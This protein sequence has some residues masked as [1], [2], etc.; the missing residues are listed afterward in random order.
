[1][2]I[3][4]IGDNVVDRYES[5][6]IMFPGGNAL[7]VAVFAR[8]AG[9]DAAYIGAIGADAAGALILRSLQ[10]EGVD[11]SRLR[12]VNGPNAYADVA[13]VDGDRQFIKSSVGVSRF[14]PDELDQRLLDDC[15]L[16]HTSAYSGLEKWVREVRERLP[17]SFDFSDQTDPDYVRELAPGLTCALFSGSG[18]TAEA[19]EDLARWVT[20]L[21]T[22][23]ALV[24][25]GEHGVVV[26]ADNGE[27]WTQAARPTEVVD[28]LGAGD[29]FLAAFLVAYLEGVPLREATARSAAAAAAACAYHG[30]FGRGGP[31]SVTSLT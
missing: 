3:V 9:A 29:A 11:I 10:E 19:C 2:R 31:I 18:L 15:D 25:R 16:A 21:G 26:C 6:G 7:N 1:M 12:V 23:I 24:S 20:S 17:I 13:I 27:L 8:R 4:G 14:L 30:A 22:K 5:L 28:T